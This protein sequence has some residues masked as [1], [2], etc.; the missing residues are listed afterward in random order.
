MILDTFISDILE[1]AIISCIYKIN[2]PYNIIDHINFVVEVLV[3]DVF[4]KV[5]II[6]E[7]K[8][9]LILYLFIKHKEYGLSIHLKNPLSSFIKNN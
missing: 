7:Y 4:I 8:K 5:Y 6:I 3:T 9:L 1:K 2:I